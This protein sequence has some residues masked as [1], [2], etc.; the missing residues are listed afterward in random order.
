MAQQI[1]KFNSEELTS[2]AYELPDEVLKYKMCGDFMGAKEAIARWLERPVAE[3]MKGRLRLELVFLE[4]LREQ[5]PYTKETAIAAFLPKVPDFTARDLERLDREDLAEWIWLDGEKHYIHNIVRN[6]IGKDRELQERA[7]LEKEEAQEKQILKDEI[8]FMRENGSST[9]R[10]HVRASIR[11]KE[12]EFYPGIVLKA[13]LPIPAK[14]YQVQEVKILSYDRG[15]KAIDPEDAL[16]RTIY[17]ED[18]L[19]ENREFYVEYEYIVKAEYHDISMAGLESA[20]RLADPQNLE[21]PEEMAEYLKEQYPHIRFSPYLRAL[22]AQIVGNETDP[23]EKARKIYDYVTTKVHY[24]YMREYF[25]IEDIPQYCARNLRG[26]CGVQALLFITL[27]RI[28]GV[29]AKWQSGLYSHPCYIGAHDWAMFYVQPY[30][31]LYADPSFGGSALA[32]EDEARREFYFGNLDPFRM[33]AN[34]AFQQ[35]F[36]NPKQ[37][38]PIDPYDNQ[39]GELESDQCGFNKD[40]VE[41]VKTLLEAVRL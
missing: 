32:D 33:P 6:A 29:P 3:G 4:Q 41:N 28:S 20:H 16:F 17:F 27:C 12:E 1:R 10:F 18:T 2:L 14:R 38:L 30:G 11:L 7:G 13:H 39:L 40:Q 15:M 25:L 35:T 23:L 26:D 5:F 9:W 19:Q 24:S 8:Q 37:F 34:N 22:A 31:W 36:L 21:Y